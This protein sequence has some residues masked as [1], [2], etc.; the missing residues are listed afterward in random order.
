MDN[1]STKLSYLTPKAKIPST[2]RSVAVINAIHAANERVKNA[3]EYEDE[4]IVQLELISAA[5]ND[6]SELAVMLRET[7]LISGC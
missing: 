1:S 5:S 2:P 6:I 7:C 3:I 4:H